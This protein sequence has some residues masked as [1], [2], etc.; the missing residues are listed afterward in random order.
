ML[1]GRSARC[2]CRLDGPHAS[3]T[4]QP[5]G[6][7]IELFTGDISEPERC[8]TNPGRDSSGA[9]GPHPHSV[10][11]TSVSL[12]T[13]TSPS[14][15]TLPPWE[16]AATV[17]RQP[18]ILGSFKLTF[19]LG[20]S[21]PVCRTVFASAVTLTVVTGVFRLFRMVRAAAARGWVTAVARRFGCGPAG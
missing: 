21:G 7:G 18:F 5:S 2:H 6:A 12:H 1:G 15:E 19:A 13:S 14:L 8:L 17:T 4:G 16:A 10:R 11:R 9:Q 20:A 3:H